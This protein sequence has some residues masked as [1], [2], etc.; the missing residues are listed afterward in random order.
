M[1]EKKIKILLKKRCR[2]AGQRGVL[3]KTYTI[4]KTVAN[5]L[6]GSGQAV[7]ADDKEAVETAK[8]FIDKLIAREKSAALEDQEETKG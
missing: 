4:E 1:A 7:K 3:G 2:I 6:L 8:I 5:Q